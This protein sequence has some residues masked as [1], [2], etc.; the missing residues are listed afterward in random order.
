LSWPATIPAATIKRQIKL[1][2]PTSRLFIS[3]LLVR[4]RIDYTPIAA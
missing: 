1:N 4:T 3:F 2:D